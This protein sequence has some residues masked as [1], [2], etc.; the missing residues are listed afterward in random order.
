L[1]E[2]RKLSEQAIE[3]CQRAGDLPS[4]LLNRLLLGAV[5]LESGDQAGAAFEADA[6][7]RLAEETR[8]PQASWI[9]QAH[10]ASRLLLDGRL[11]AVEALA[12]A[13][14]LA[15]Q[16]TRDHNALLTFGVHLS[17]VRI[18]QG[19]SEE[20]LQVIRDYAARYPR[21]VGWRVLYAYALGRAGQL[22][23][24]AAEYQSLSERG[25]ALPDDLNWMVSM[26]WLVETCHALRDVAGASLLY[27]RFSP[28]ADRLVV[29]G[30]AGIACLGSVQRYLGLLSAT[31]G[32]WEVAIAHFERAA[33]AN[34]R[35]LAHLPLAYTL[36]DCAGARLSA[37]GQQT[38]TETVRRYL[39]EAE[40]FARERNLSALATALS[41]T[42][43]RIAPPDPETMRSP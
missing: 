43:A 18:E 11:D 32:S 10:R 4:L 3:L 15:G 23:A 20:V 25:F 12:G 8:Q 31:Q 26:A 9:V 27:E 7:R 6:F 17:L 33:Q 35:T 24:C 14:L 13:C 29:I 22:S 37:D 41:A 38:Q 1:E 42:R 39:D 2:R 5:L 19:R 16:R 40:A 36:H 30:Y 21:I 28:F 34:R